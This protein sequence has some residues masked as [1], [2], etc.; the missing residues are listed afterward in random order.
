[1]PPSD[2]YCRQGFFEGDGGIQNRGELLKNYKTK[3]YGLTELLLIEISLHTYFLF[4]RVVVLELCFGH[5]SK[6]KNEQR[7]ITSKLGK[8]ELWL[9]FTALSHNEI[10]IPSTSLADTLCPFIVITHVNFKV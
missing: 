2:S 10:Y 4:I 7:E 9:F 5:T 3:S 6:C 8:A 1:M